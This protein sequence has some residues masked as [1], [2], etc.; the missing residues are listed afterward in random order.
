MSRQ[1][2]EPPTCDEM[3]NARIIL[4]LFTADDDERSNKMSQKFLF[5]IYST[6]AHLAFKY[7]MAPGV[8]DWI[9]L[10]GSFH[11]EW[12]II[13]LISVSLGLLS[14]RC[15]W[16][17]IWWGWSLHSIKMLFQNHLRSYRES[18]ILKMGWSVTRLQKGCEIAPQ[19][20]VKYGVRF[21]RGKTQSAA[22]GSR[23]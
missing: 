17:P 11:E 7:W 12:Q 6:R 13:W 8:L 10:F 18:E 1:Q 19:M 21:N 14:H 16:N 4:L 15:H 9:F 3:T 22:D 5:P 23:N 2:G 20:F